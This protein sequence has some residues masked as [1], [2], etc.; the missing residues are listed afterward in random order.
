ML[1][2]LREQAQ[3]AAAEAA[4][5]FRQVR[6]RTVFQEK[7]EDCAVRSAGMLIL[8][9]SGVAACWLAYR[10]VQSMRATATPKTDD[11]YDRVDEASMESFPASDPPSFSPGT[12]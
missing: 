8:A 7:N 5:R 3:N 10:A 1:A 9:A 2:D 6:S 11:D 12:T 4:D